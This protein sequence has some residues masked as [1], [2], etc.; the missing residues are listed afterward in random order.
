M[1]H[2]LNGKDEVY[3]ALAEHLSRFPVGAVIN[4]TLMEILRRLYTESEAGLG[5]RIPLKPTA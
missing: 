2:L 3:R 5:S 1:G 4:E